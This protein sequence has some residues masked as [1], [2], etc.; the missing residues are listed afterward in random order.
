MFIDGI[1]VYSKSKE[2]HE[3]I[4]VWYCRSFEAIDYMPS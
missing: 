4:S 3:D 1:F 2:E